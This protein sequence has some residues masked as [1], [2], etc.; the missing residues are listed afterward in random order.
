MRFRT[1][2]PAVGKNLTWFVVLLLI[3][4]LSSVLALAGQPDTAGVPQR[5]VLRSAQAV[6]DEVLRTNPNARLMPDGSVYLGPA[7]PQDIDV[8]V[9]N[10]N[11]ADTV[12][13]DQLWSGGGMGLSL[14]GS[15]V[16]VGLWDGGLI[17][18]THNELVGRVT[19]IDSGSAADHSTHVAGTIGATGVSPS[20]HGMANAVLF[21]SR[22]LVNDAAEMAADAGVINLSNHSYGNLRGW[23]TR[24]DWGIGLVD[25]W[26]ADRASYSVEDPAFGK[27]EGSANALDLALFGSSQLANAR[28]LD[29]LLYDNPH[30]LAVW[31]AGNDR[32][33]YFTNALGT[34]QYVSY[35]SNQS[36]AGFYLLTGGAPTSDGGSTG[37]D[38][39]PQSQ[40]AK[41]TLVVGAIDD[42]T[43]D[44]YTSGNV[45]LASF[46]V[47]GPCD[48]GRVKPDLVA[49]GLG[50][51][52]S[53]A[54][55]DNAYA[56]Y[57]GT[58]MSSPNAC[59]TA[60]LI[61]QHY[62]SFHAGVLPT[63]AALKG[64]MIHTAFDAGNVGPDYKYGW[65]VL[66]GA[67]AASFLSDSESASP[68]F[69]HL[70]QNTYTGTTQDFQY[71]SPG[72][73][74]VKATLVWT[75]PAPTTL[76][77][78]GLDDSTKALVNDLDLKII[79]PGAV[80]YWPWTLSR[81]SPGN[82]AV[83]TVRNQVDNVEQVL[84]DFPAAGSYTIRVSHTGSSPTQAYS[85][86]ISGVT[87]DTI[88]P[89]ITICAPPQSASAN[90][91]G[92]A[93]VPDFT[94]TV[95]ATDNCTPAGSLVIT[96]SPLAGTL[97]GLGDTPVTI[98]VRDL[99]TNQATCGTT[100]TV[101]D[102][103]APTISSVEIA[104]Q[105][106]KYAAGDPIH[107]TVSATDNVAVTSVAANTVSLVHGGGSTWTGDITA[108]S[109][110]GGY[111][112]SVVALDA[113]TNSSTNT[114][115][116]YTVY[117]LV[118]VAAKYPATTF[119]T[120]ACANYLF[121]FSGKVMA[122]EM[123]SFMLD[124]L[125]GMTIQVNA[126]GYSGIAANDMVFARGILDIAPEP[127]TLTC[128]PSHLL[129]Y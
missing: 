66:N 72:D 84:I 98:T 49:N 83:R 107:V 46:S 123:N 8:R 124:T 71:C 101:T 81:T 20:A 21:R 12:N 25:T 11:A 44:P 75:D 22:D 96:Q 9:F 36:P 125:A 19:V 67:A 58:S 47:F 4:S 39:L 33:E 59:G 37:F 122:T 63:S 31:S 112:V 26:M 65:G 23:T 16:T 73:R 62:R 17:R 60:A 108:Q 103:T 106:A 128:D 102:N 10:I 15:G 1:Q 28:A 35:L 76:P 104:P 74:P 110:S 45:V 56:S 48:D 14:N 88:S 64:V 118:F 38:T 42:I 109:A 89:T 57:S 77:G 41:N 7:L 85:L 52:S 119:S 18:A 24:I 126:P 113:A 2:L 93:A 120:W 95:V 51:Y 40:V 111:P 97:V 29:T 115:Q 100:F 53:V 92:Q 6:V 91:S 34:G 116:S 90:G 50:L 87:S 70:F 55:A 5:P 114:S 68:S 27:Y 94:S 30:L 32:G 105:P 127:D 117:P 61:L 78:S 13:A 43:A 129:K 86:L 79:G 99:A 3:V 82:A 80:A 121:A 69:N 54:T